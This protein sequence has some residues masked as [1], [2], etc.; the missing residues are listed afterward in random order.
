MVITLVDP[1]VTRRKFCEEVALWKEHGDVGKRGWLLL[2]ENLTE[3]S[4][5]LALMARVAT[6]VAVG[7]LPVVV[8]AIR[9]QYDN[10][11]L[12]PPSMT[13]IDVFTREPSHPHVRAFLSTTEG[14]RDVLIEGHPSTGR[15]FLC[16]PGIREYH[17][18]PQHTGDDWLL[19]RSSREG[20]IST[21]TERVWRMMARNVIGLGVSVQALPVFPLRAQV[22]IQVAQ[23]EL[24]GAL[25]V[26]GLSPPPAVAGK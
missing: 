4:V 9:L 25:S 10:Y 13:F 21:I 5:E 6:S 1:E 20:S 17:S 16:L 11:D 23:G 14:P 7:F 3:P 24:E 8:C 2:T 15:A 19:H 22:G 12:W 18:H 26:V